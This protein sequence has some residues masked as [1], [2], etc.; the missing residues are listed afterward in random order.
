MANW[1]QIGG[2]VILEDGRSDEGHCF[3]VPG[4]AKGHKCEA[5]RSDCEAAVQAI[6]LSG[7]DAL[8]A[9]LNPERLARGW[10]GLTSDSRE[11]AEEKG[12]SKPG[13]EYNSP[14]QAII[15]GGGTE[16]RPFYA[17]REYC[18]LC[19][20][21]SS[22]KSL[23]RWLPVMPGMWPLRTESPEPRGRSRVFDVRSRGVPYVG[24][25]GSPTIVSA[26]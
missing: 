4:H 15:S 10:Y 12:C 25:D 26:V 3:L 6:D 7:G 16:S 20:G 19:E 14:Q 5:W 24:F 2:K 23:S 8:D 11:A 9:L 21:A 18:Q 17:G 22:G 1:P 13:Q